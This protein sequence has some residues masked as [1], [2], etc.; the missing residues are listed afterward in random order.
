MH[1]A[2]SRLDEPGENGNRNGNVANGDE[3][4]DELGEDA[5]DGRV[6]GMA[7]AK[8]LKHAP[9]AMI[10]VIAKHDHGDDVEKRDGPDLKAKDKVVIDVVV[11]ERRAR[12]H[13]TEGELEKVPDDEGEDDGATPHH[14]A[15][16]VSG[17]ETGF[18]DVLDGPGFA[19]EEPEF[20]GRPDVQEDGNQK[21][22][23]GGPH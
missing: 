12:V 17:I 10:E 20:E 11:V 2:L 9:E 18:L 21:G 4:G 5:Q 7:E 3:D 16:G 13:G 1:I 8:R 6:H 19:L 23:T 14:G 22:D 15:R